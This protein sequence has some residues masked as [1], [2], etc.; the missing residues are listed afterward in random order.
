MTSVHTA[1]RVTSLASVVN[2]LLNLLSTVIVAR[3]LTPADIGVFSIAVSLTAFAHILREFGI[4][5]FLV[6]LKDL[7]RD[8]LRAGFTALLMIAWTLAAVM[9]LAAIP[10]A[11]FYSQPGVRDVFWVLALNFMVLPF[12]S[13]VMIMLKRDLQFDKLAWVAIFNGVVQT[14]VTLLLAWQGFSY[15]SMAWGTLAGNVFNVLAFWFLRPEIAWLRPTRQYLQPMFSF[16]T[17]LSSASMLGQLGSSAPDLILGKTQSVAEVAQFSRAGGLLNMVVARI[18][19][20]LIQVF[21]AV[22]AKHIREGQDALPLLTRAIRLHSGVAL[23][24]IAALAVISQPLTLFMFGE[25]WHE[26]ATLAPVLTA[27][28]ALVAPLTL[29]PYALVSAGHVGASL[30]ANLWLNGVLIG[31]LLSSIWLS[32]MQMTMLLIVAR[33]TYAMAWIHQLRQ[34]FGFGSR[35]LLIAILPSLRLTAWVLIPMLLM[36]P[37]G[38]HLPPVVYIGLQALLALIAFMLG[39]RFGHHPLQ[40]ELPKL[41][42][43]LRHL[44]LPRNPCL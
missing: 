38:Q 12:G 32:L 30:R 17:T 39:V 44:V 41:L 31:V 37:L 36:L 20:I 40:T 3:L 16:G 25:Q 4:G 10:V 9:A 43:P 14:G 26:A 13:H 15:M 22:F 7:T 11:A 28:A 27:Y 24:M 23:P 34:H 33:M 18:D 19:A 6:Q 29:A 1:I 8:H 35:L 5:Q 21:A 42:P 2:L